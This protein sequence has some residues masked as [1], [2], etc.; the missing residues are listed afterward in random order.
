MHKVAIRFA[1]SATG[2]L[3][4]VRSWYA[5]Q[6]VPD[7]GDRF[8]QAI[9]ARIEALRV[10]PEMGR[11]V[12]ELDRPLLRELIHPPFLI[13]YHLEPKRPRQ[14]APESCQSSTSSQLA[15]A[16]CGT[17]PAAVYWRLATRTW[18]SVRAES[19]GRGGS[20]LVRPAR[21]QSSGK[22]G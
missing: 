9:I 20:D 2:D 19:R 18:N 11:I 16:G 13:V 7:G 6:G 21:S 15:L 8:V 12:P 1:K 5:D 3:Q 17:A 10:H 22:A 14:R 4:A